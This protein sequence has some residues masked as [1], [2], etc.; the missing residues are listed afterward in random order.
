M[1]VF[2]YI[3]AILKPLIA[4]NNIVCWMFWI[5]MFIT[6]YKDLKENYEKVIFRIINGRNANGLRK[7]RNGK[8]KSV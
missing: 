7:R 2:K 5:G 4:D 1:E 8:S 3:W 6:Y